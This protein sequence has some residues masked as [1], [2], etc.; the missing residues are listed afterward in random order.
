[1]SFEK[2][3]K[4]APK[5]LGIGVIVVSDTRSAAMREG[6][7]VDVSG[8]IIEREVRKAGHGSR[9]VI[10][11]DEAA[12]ISK[13]LKKFIGD[14]GIDSVI[15]TG[16]TGLAK[17]DVTIETVEPLY[18]KDLPGFGEALRHFGY[19]QV[20][21]PALLTR[22]S[23]GVIKRKPVFCLPGAPN[24]VKV[25]MKLILPDLAHVVKHARD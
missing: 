7:D 3:R 15:L 10:V 21:T 8:K 18:D 17:R 19:A 22:C 16:G 11:P 25:A 13:A 23:A 2:H 4:D 14:K 5:K 9:R 12:E 20:G 6:R 24:A 1:M